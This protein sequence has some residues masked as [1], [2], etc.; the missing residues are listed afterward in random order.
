MQVPGIGVLGGGPRRGL[1]WGGFPVE[2]EGKREGVGEGG[3]TGDR[4]RNWQVNVHS[5]VKTTLLAN[6]PSVSH[7][8]L[9]ILQSSVNGETVL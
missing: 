6:C 5:L 7:W 3:W 4:Q 1:G 8:E 9:K 2:D